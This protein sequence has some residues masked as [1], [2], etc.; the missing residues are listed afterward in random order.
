[1][2]IRLPLLETERLHLRPLERRDAADVQRYASD[3]E[4][5]ANTLVI[6]HPYP[7]GAAEAFIQNT[8]EEARRGEAYIYAIVLKT[9][10]AL[11]GVIGL[12]PQKEHDR[13]EIGYWIGRPFWNQGY[14]TEAARALVAFGF[15]ELGLN[16]IYARYFLRNPAS[17]RVQQKIGMRYEGT[18]RQEVK[19]WGIYEDLGVN[20]ILRSEYEAGKGRP[21]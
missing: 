14:A 1:M 7:D 13:A 5:A 18:L 3:R 10:S 8:Y 16:R 19:K 11:V 6:P 20:A 21:S 17:G 15:E 9:D 4:V 12:H 2:F